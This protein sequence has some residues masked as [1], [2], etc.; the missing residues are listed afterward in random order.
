M[1]PSFFLQRFWGRDFN[2]QN[3]LTKMFTEKASILLRRPERIQRSPV[4][5]SEKRICDLGG[6]GLWL[7][8]ILQA[9]QSLLVSNY[10]PTL[11][12]PRPVG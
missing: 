5:T 8:S 1:S 12:G 10:L 6:G 4:D 3:T 2:P 11:I 7:Y 9:S